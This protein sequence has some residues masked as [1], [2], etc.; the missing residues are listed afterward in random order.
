MRHLEQ[1]KRIRPLDFFK[2]LPFQKL[3]VESK[4]RIKAIF[5][6]NRAGKTE[7]GA[8]YVIERARTTPNLR[9]WACAETFKKSIDIQQRKVW[10]LL[11]KDEVRYC[12]YDEING[13]RHNKIIFKNGTIIV[14][15]S[16][17]QK[18]GAFES[19]DIDIIWN[20]EE[21]PYEIYREQRMRLVDRN[22]EMI[23]TMT[24][25]MGMTDLMSELFDDHNI[26][27]SEL[28]EPLGEDLPRIV[29][30]NGM[31]FFMMWTTENPHVNQQTLLEEIAIMPRTE[32][33]SRVCGIP[34]N[35]AGRIYT[36]FNKQIHVVGD[37]SIPERLV[38]LYHILDPH[39]A[40]PWAM[41]WWSASKNGSA[42]C[43]RE[44]PW[45]QNFN[46]MEYDDK[47]YDDYANIIRE[48]EDELFE[49]FG[50]LVQVR[51]IDP[52]FGHKTIKLAKRVDGNSKT[53]PVK[54]LK[55]RGFKFEDAV[56]DIMSG[57][58]QVRKL[59]R[60]EEKDGELVIR[61]QIYWHED[62]ENSIRHM[63]KYS[64]KDLQGQDGD[65]RKTPQLTQKYKDFCDL[66]RYGSQRGFRYLEKITMSQEP[67]KKR[68]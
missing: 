21:P 17:D 32:V 16:Y 33:R 13:F 20:D 50:R 31:V 55:S 5:G 35:L 9:I 62:C 2:L 51:I 40:K 64:Y 24:S 63:N 18:R 12:F 54:E 36:S 6:G 14:F 23:F 56:D 61:P 49:R 3:F 11:P 57:H 22:G 30:K 52:N 53:T 29:E 19:D 67:A 38:T 66:V 15:K 7:C 26:V 25:L 68:Y 65:D 44:Y 39:D 10:Q 42:Y 47:T 48:T 37:E 60:W 45:K 34:T 58:M 43:V 59:L 46:E 4:A 28:F 41:Q 1:R 27:R 8:Y